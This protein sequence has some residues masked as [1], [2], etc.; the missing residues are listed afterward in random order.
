MARKKQ[1][2]KRLKKYQ[3]KYVTADRLD[4]SKGGRVQKAVGGLKKAPINR[5]RPPMSIQREEKPKE[6]KPIQPIKKKP[7][8]KT[9]KQVPKQAVQP[10]NLTTG[11]LG[12]DRILPTGPAKTPKYWKTYSTW[13][14]W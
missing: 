7:I 4:M 12:R 14:C 6:L 11:G 8:Q 13:W 5:R 10:G 1:Q 3:G 2:K 9:V